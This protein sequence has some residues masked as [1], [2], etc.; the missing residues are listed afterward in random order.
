[1]GSRSLYA[2][3]GGGAVVLV[4]VEVAMKYPGNLVCLAGLVV[5]VLFCFFISS[6]P[7][8]VGQFSL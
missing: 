4:V 1:L 3:S 8:K 5:F 6:E 7:E 2:L